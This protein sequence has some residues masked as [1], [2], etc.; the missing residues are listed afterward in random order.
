MKISYIVTYVYDKGAKPSMMPF[1]T[2]LSAF[3]EYKTRTKH[4]EPYD[5]ELA[6]YIE[7]AGHGPYKLVLLKLGD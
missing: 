1:T 5:I 4:L 3:Q 6:Q 2:F 7:I